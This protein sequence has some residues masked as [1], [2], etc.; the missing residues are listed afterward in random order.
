MFREAIWLIRSR[1][2]AKPIAWR[3]VRSCT[4]GLYFASGHLARGHMLNAS[5]VNDGDGALTVSMF[6]VLPS[7]SKFAGLTSGIMSISPSVSARSTASEL[8]YLI[9]CNSSKAGFLPRQF[10]LRSMRTSVL[11][12]NSV[13]MYG[14]LPTIGGFGR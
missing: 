5:S 10:G 13:T 9:H 11:E 14:P 8:P 2:T 1:S 4:A 6:S 7:R 12:S 3:T